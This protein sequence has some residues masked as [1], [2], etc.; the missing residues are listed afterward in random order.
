M[1]RI[2]IIDDEKEACASLKRM[3]EECL[4]SHYLNA[5]IQ[6]FC[7]AMRFVQNY[8]AGFDL[9]F[10]DI[11]MPEMDGMRAA[12]LIRAKD[13]DVLLIFVTSMIQ[14]AVQDYRVEALDYIC[15]DCGSRTA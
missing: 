14:Y 15:K 12:E 6:T 3:I 10:L 9:I 13:T 2:A 8:E 1:I 5:E 4:L 7:D 11:Q